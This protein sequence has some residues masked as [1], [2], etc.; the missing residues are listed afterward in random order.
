MTRA[1]TPKAIGLLTIASIAVASATR[2]QAQK[3]P[4]SELLAS[5]QRKK[6]ARQSGRAGTGKRV[7]RQGIRV[8]EQPMRVTAKGARQFSGIYPHLAVFNEQGE[9]GIGGLVPWADKLWW[10]TYAPHKPDGSD[11]GLYAMDADRQ[12]LRLPESIGGTPANRF[13]HR[14]TQQLVLGPYII[15]RR[16]A[17]RV[18]PYS[19]MRGRPTGNARHLF[20]PAKKLYLATMEEGF[21]E[22]DLVD[23][24]VRTLFPDGHD[25]RARHNRLLPGYHG[26]GLYS[27]Q[28]V[29]VY[30]NN[31]ESSREALRR[32]DVASGCLA[33]WDGKGAWRVIRRNQFTEVSGPGG[34][35]G[36]SKK[37]EPIWSI[38]WDH[39]SL[40]LMLRS[41]GKWSSYRL[42]KASHCYDG[43]HG[44]NTEWPRIRDIGERDFL[45]TMHGTFWR[46]PSGFDLGRTSGIAPRSTYLKVVGDFCRYGDK[47]VLAC[48]DA[49]KN[50]FLNTR[51]AKGKL[52]GPAQ[53]Q[54]NLCF[55]DPARLDGFGPPIGRGALWLDEKVN[56]GV[57]SDPFLFAGYARRGLH[58]GQ[59]SG[60]RLGFVLE[61][62]REGTGEWTR[63]R[64]VE[65]GD[66]A[67]VSFDESERGA[68]IRIVPSAACV[69]TAGFEYSARDERSAT[70][71]AKFAGLATKLPTNAAL[72]RAGRRADGLEVIA[73]RVD[74]R[75]S[76]AVGSYRLG[77]DL[78]LE[79]VEQSEA[80][81]ARRAAAI[82]LKTDVL[83]FVGKSVLYVDETG[84][85]FRLPIGNPAYG[86][87]PGRVDLQRVAREV[88][89]ERDLFQAAGTFYE[90]PA[91]NAGGFAKI[92]PIATHPF[93]VQDYCSWRGLLVL[94]GIDAS[95]AI[96]DKHIVRSGDGKCALWLGSVDD[97]WSL[98]KARGVGGPWTRDNVERRDVSDAY[99]MAGFDR[100]RLEITHDRDE[101]VEFAISVDISGD[102]RWR[103]HHKLVAQPNKKT[104]YAFPDGF[105]AYWVRIAAGERCRVSAHFVY[106]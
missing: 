48:D 8:A 32:P 27:S 70:P 35:S 95:A 83:R 66:N 14:E 34:I 2:A 87:H 84:R 44:W 24:T 31:G 64:Q 3:P 79:R 63:L 90:L 59:S 18:I 4:V 7:A 71:H 68:W 74:E 50:E 25:T 52:A 80:Q 102:G 9:C 43:A 53:S 100:K 103:L 65:V 1:W 60:R 11:D 56:A 105:A 28:G 6:R 62:D 22:V 21:Y 41:A 29:L 88:A 96:E 61:V 54:S 72:L 30:A 23:Y 12:L 75:A 57:P 89:T 78:K 93:F 99:L 86:R 39:R 69:A 38:G 82:A 104:A 49:A 42:P 20:D 55:V 33:E 10:L 17:V 101:P 76:R 92:R 15:D 13:V 16:G 94:S 36:N 40:I 81:R 106:D 91:R 51:K 67:W 46:F 26:K 85:R 5:A 19:I 58:L 73:T 98:G 47:V 37:G 97:L 45:M 77:P